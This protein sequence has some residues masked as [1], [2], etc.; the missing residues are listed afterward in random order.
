M[1]PGVD[2]A[3]LADFEHRYSVSLP[4]DFRDFL[5]LANGTVPPGDNGMYCL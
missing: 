2:E 4:Q 1:L 5:R 3:T